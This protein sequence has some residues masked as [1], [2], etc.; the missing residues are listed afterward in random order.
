M[1]TYRRIA[2]EIELLGG[3]DN[4]KEIQR[5]LKGATNLKSKEISRI[6]WEKL[7]EDKN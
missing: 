5:L 3:D 6:L 7:R 4:L 1:H 2:K